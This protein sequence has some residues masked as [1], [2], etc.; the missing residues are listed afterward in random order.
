METKDFSSQFQYIERNGC[1][2]NLEEK[3]KLGLALGEL[4]A[5]LNLTKCYIMGKVTGK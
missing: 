2:F 4:K 1:T 5:D 3:M